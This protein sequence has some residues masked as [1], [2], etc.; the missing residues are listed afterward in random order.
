MSRRDRSGGSGLS[1]GVPRQG[2]RGRDRAG[3]TAGAPE[4]RAG[5]IDRP[6]VFDDDT[7]VTTRARDLDRLVA[8]L[9]D[10]EAYNQRQER[11]LRRAQRDAERERRSQLDGTAVALERS[12][13]GFFGSTRRSFGRS[14]PGARP[15]VHRRFVARQFAPA[16][17]GLAPRA[18]TRRTR[19]DAPAPEAESTDFVP[20]DD[21]DDPI[22]IHDDDDFDPG[23]HAVDDEIRVDSHRVRVIEDERRSD[24]FLTFPTFATPQ[25]RRLRERDALAGEVGELRRQVSALT[26]YVERLGATPPRLVSRGG[27]FGVRHGHGGSFGGRDASLS[28]RRSANSDG[29]GGGGG[30]G[31]GSTSG[32]RRGRPRIAP[33]TGR[34][35][36]TCTEDLS[37]SVSSNT[38]RITTG[39]VGTTGRSLRIAR[40]PRTPSS[41]SWS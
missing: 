11:T 3:G 2:P 20:S 23:S 4:E 27:A 17:Q 19:I 38:P 8:E 13:D 24:P 21:L 10:L 34:I 9:R 29:G 37:A 40:T 28:V 31:A 36:R 18:A 25:H 5:L 7:T 26:R 30:G 22:Q 33:S 15:R 35:T 41:T 6:G 32:S 12:S 14:P 16:R 39:P 1:R